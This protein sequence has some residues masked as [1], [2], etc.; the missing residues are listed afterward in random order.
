MIRDVIDLSWEIARLRRIKVGILKAS[1][2]GGVR[3]VLDSLGH[4]DGQIFRTPETSAG[5]G[6]LGTKA[7]RRK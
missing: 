5:D 7:H 6:R 1:M 4:G 3:A 2:S